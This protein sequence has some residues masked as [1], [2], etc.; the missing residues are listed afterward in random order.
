MRR[1]SR[2]CARSSSPSKASRS[3]TSM[4][5][6]SGHDSELITTTTVISTRVSIGPRRRG[7][8]RIPSIL[9]FNE[10][11]REARIPAGRAA[12]GAARRPSLSLARS[13]ILL[14]PG[15]A[16]SQSRIAAS[17]QKLY[18]LGI[19]SKVETA[20]Q[21]PDGIEDS[22]Y[23]LVRADESGRY[24]LMPRSAPSWDASEAA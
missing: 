19:F 6:R 10:S 21:N 17:Q 23:V 18:D 20:I 1:N 13:R 8:P 4:W 15:D 24:S 11:T 5:P 16:I 9:L 22:K 7:R 3:A 12:P 2:I 14:R